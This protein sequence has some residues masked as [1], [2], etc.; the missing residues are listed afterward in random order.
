MANWASFK[1][2]IPA[3]DLLAPVQQLLEMLLLFLEILKVILGTIKAFLI[4]FG[5]PLRILLEALIAL[6]EEF[7]EALKATGLFA[8][9]DVPLSLATIGRMKGGYQGF[10][11]RFKGSLYDF[12]DYNRPQPRTSTTSGFILLVVDQSNPFSM[13]DQISRLLRL[14]GK[15]ATA[16]RFD[17]VGN[18]QV[19]PISSIGDPIFTIAGAFR[20]NINT[21]ALSWTLPTTVETADPGFK[22]ALSNLTD[23]FGAPHYVIEKSVDI[24]PAATKID[25]SDLAN[26]DSTGIVEFDNPV[27][28]DA[29]L[30]SRF[31]KVDGSTVTSRE[32]LR[33]ADSGGEPFIKFQRYIPL[34]RLDLALGQLGRYRYIDKDVEVGHTYYYRVRAYSGQLNIKKDRLKDLPANLKQL[35]AGFGSGSSTPAFKWVSA[36]KGEEVLMGKPSGLAVTTIPDVPP[37]FDVMGNLQNLF[38]VAFS[39]DFHLPLPAVQY[40]D[41]GQPL[42]GSEVVQLDNQGNPVGDTPPFY[43]GRGSLT[44]HASSL[45]AFSALPILGLLAQLDS[46]AAAASAS[47]I[48]LP[49]QMFNVRR[50]AARLADIIGAAMLQAGGGVVYAFRDFMQGPLPRGPISTT[51]SDTTTLERICL[52]LT[53][54]TDSDE[55]SVT[56]VLTYSNAYSKDLGL[57][58][59]ILAVVQFLKSFGLEGEPVDWISISPL[60][61]I[62]P[63]A[64]QL[65]YDLLDKIQAL[66]DSFNSVLDEIRLFIDLLE[67]KIEALEKFIQW[68]IDI[69]SFIIELKFGAYILTSFGLHGDASSW[70][71]AIDNAGGDVPSSGPDG[72]TSGIGLA[73]VAI[74]PG[75]F[76]TALQLIFG[77]G[78]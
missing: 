10:I 48:E 57:R 18:F 29:T 5:N 30:A 31:A 17:P 49:W 47:K 46:P 72:F 25:L 39:L 63:W 51:L 37:D 23:E 32:V 26:D 71:E 74:D 76:V 66:I 19:G 20:E 64:G 38:K 11:E 27:A 21:I 73:Y 67:R 34:S 7:F 9:F 1:F 8:Y 78:G 13:M 70:I 28:I 60:R 36:E 2:E 56:T 15:A 41:D 45:A 61:D 14:F 65:L 33:E 58:K 68:L 69:L 52:I 62:I 75:T 3:T 4:D 42:P 22:D 77:G 40:G 53:Q 50:Q 54:P 59:N 44:K 16:P 43:V 6:I 55:N 35:T 12:K 24:N